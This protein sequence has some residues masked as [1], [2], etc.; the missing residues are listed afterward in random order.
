MPERLISSLEVNIYCRDFSKAP[1]YNKDM[2]THTILYVANQKASSAFYQ[3]VL[4]VPPRLDVPGMTEFQ[5]SAE[6]VLG[7]MPEAGIRRIL[8]DILPDPAAA[9]GIPRVELY[10]RVSDPEAGLSRGLEAGAKL[11]SPLMDRDWG[12]KAGYL[13]DP[14]GHVLAFA[15]DFREEVSA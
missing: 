11:L 12:D 10:F 6:H 4:E 9:N 14:D 8:G 1:S 13:L 5:L 3:R 7:L 15:T 2:I